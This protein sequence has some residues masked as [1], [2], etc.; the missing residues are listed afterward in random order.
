M[1]P[2]QDKHPE[3]VFCSI[4]SC[5]AEHSPWQLCPVQTRTQ[6]IVS[7]LRCMHRCTFM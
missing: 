4:T 6:C 1:P 5:S 7:I 3:I 2:T